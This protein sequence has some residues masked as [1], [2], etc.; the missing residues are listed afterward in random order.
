[1]IGEDHLAHYPMGPE[2]FAGIM[3]SCAQMGASL[4]GGCC[5]TAPEF[6]A[7]VRQRLS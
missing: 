3:T 7:A 2:E 4:L 5:G 1:M 6:I